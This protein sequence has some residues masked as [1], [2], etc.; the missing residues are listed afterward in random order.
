MFEKPMRQ[1]LDYVRSIAKD[2]FEPI[3]QTWVDCGRWLLPHRAKCLTNEQE[4]KRSNQHIVDATH[5]LAHRSY[6]AGFLEGNTSA[7][8]PW[9]RYEDV[10]PDINKD[11]QAKFYF[12]T[13]NKRI[14]A[15]LSTSNFY[16]AAA[17]VYGDIGCFNTGSYYIEELPRGLHFHVLEPGTYYVLNDGYGEAVVLVR[18]FTLTVKAL[19]ETYGKKVNGQW[20]WSNFSHDVK[21]MYMDG[22]YTGVVNVAHIV[23]KNVNYNLEKPIAGLNRQWLSV[24]YETGCMDGNTYVPSMRGGGITDSKEDIYLNIKAS[25]RK[26]FVIAKSVSSKNY[27]YGEKGPTTDSLGLIKSLNKKAINKDIAIEKMIKPTLYGPAS[28]KK[29]YITQ[30]PNSYIPVDANSM[31]LGGPRPIDNVNPAIG[32]LIQDV[33]DLRSMVDKLY[34]ADFLMFLSRNPKTRTATETNAILSEQQLIIGPNLQ[35][36]DRT[37]NIPILDY[38]ADYVLDEDPYMPPPP[39]ILMGRPIRPV[40]ISVFAQAQRAADLPAVERYLAVVQNVGQIDPSIFQKVNVDAIADIYD[41]RLY[42]PA[43][44]N[45]SQSETEAIRR[46]AQQRAQQQQMLNETLPNVAG[47][48]KDIGLKVNSGE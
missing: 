8:R 33:G 19:V 20:D 41:D 13:L 25:K 45:R 42:L 17:I 12:E 28:I 47:A 4:G 11:P 30:A 21:K 35:S 10:D 23:E 32:T 31:Q 40:M 5:V 6:V 16:D 3:R 37:H 48:A 34:Y 22:N 29:S 15:T 38:V 26:P 39:D 14:F 27:E 2:R 46:A 1:H 18:E 9:A 44:L 7:T 43:G 36:L 24:T